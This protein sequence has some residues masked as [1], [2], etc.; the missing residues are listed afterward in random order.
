M[1]RVR[2]QELSELSHM[3]KEDSWDSDGQNENKEEKADQKD[4]LNKEIT[5]CVRY[6]KVLKIKKGN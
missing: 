5:R 3:R 4:V 6:R 2:G 1:E